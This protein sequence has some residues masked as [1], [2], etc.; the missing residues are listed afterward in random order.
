MRAR[1]AAWHRVCSTLRMCISTQTRCRSAQHRQRLLERGEDC[2]ICPPQLVRIQDAARQ[3]ALAAGYGPA[4]RSLLP[5]AC[6]GQAVA[7]PLVSLTAGLTGCWVPVAGPWRQQL[8]RSWALLVLSWCPAAGV[9]WGFLGLAQTVQAHV[10]CRAPLQHQPLLPLVAACLSAPTAGAQAA[11][12]QT[13][14]PR[15]CSSPGAAA[16]CPQPCAACQALQLP[17]GG[18]LL[19]VRPWLAPR[20]VRT[21]CAAC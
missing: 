5:P 10:L 15:L 8:R 11:R 2:Q 17:A 21:A 6:P 13:A 1:P 9:P 16:P 7:G 20:V 18:R 12:C 14:P 4:R 19:P 3:L